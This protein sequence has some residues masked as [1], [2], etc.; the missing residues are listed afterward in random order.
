MQYKERQ[1]WERDS[2]KEGKLWKR[3]SAGQR[4]SSNKLN[5]LKWQSTRCSWPVQMGKYSNPV[6]SGSFRRQCVARRCAQRQNIVAFKVQTLSCLVVVG[7]GSCS[8]C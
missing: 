5:T 7:A 2:D 4:G 3:G 6:G 8:S 1:L